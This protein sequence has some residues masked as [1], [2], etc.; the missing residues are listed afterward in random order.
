MVSI[1]STVSRRGVLLL[2]VLSVLTL[3]LMLGA[4]YV[5]VASRARKASRAFADNVVASTAGGMAQERLLDQAFM[6]VARGTLAKK[7]LSPASDIDFLGIGANGGDDLLGDKYGAMTAKGRVGTCANV[8]GSPA[9][10]RLTGTFTSGTIPTEI[11]QY[12]GRVITLSL[13]GLSASTRVISATGS[14]TSPSLFV[15]GGPTVAGEPLS[16]QRITAAIAASST[17]AT[18]L[19]LNGRE[20]DGSGANEPYD[21]YD[22]LNPLLTRTGTAVATTGTAA[23]N[24]GTTLTVDNDADGIADSAF[25]DVGLPPLLGANGQIVYP[26]AAILVL[27]LD[28]RLN[29]NAH[30]SATDAETIGRYPALNPSLTLSS[31][32]VPQY[33]LPRGLASGPADV[34][35]SRSL[36]F[37]STTSGTSE[38]AIVQAATY[39]LAGAVPSGYDTTAV[40][41]EVP[42]VGPVEGRFGDAVTSGS[43]AAI[44]GG[45]AGTG[46]PNHNDEVSHAADRWRVT[47]S[48]SHSATPF[49]TNPGRFGT[50]WDVKGQIR[51]WADEFGQPVFFKPTWAGDDAKDD[52]YEVNLT[53]LGSRN[54]YSTS[55][56]GTTPGDTLFTPAELEGL[57]RYYDPDSLKLPRRLVAISGS[58][59]A[60]NRLRLTTES[61]D[62][63]AVTGTTWHAAIQA[64]FNAMLNTADLT[65]PDRSFD[66]LS[67]ETLMGHKFDINRPFHDTD[68]EEPNDAKGT[69]RRQAFARHLYCLMIAVADK[70]NVF[71]GKNPTERA[72]LARQIAQYAVNVVD[73]RD[74]DSVMTRFAFDPQFGPSDTTWS[75]GPDDYVWGCE[76]PELLITETLAWHDRRTDD[77]AVNGKVV[78]KT[79][80][81]K[82]FDQVR[83]PRGAFFVELYSPWQARMAQPASGTA[84]MILAGSDSRADPIPGVLR[85]T[86]SFGND[87]GNGAGVTASTISLHKTSSGFPVWRLVSV[88]GRVLGGTAI[89]AT[90]KTLVDP[91][92]PGSTAIVDRV[93]Y[94]GD[95]TNSGTAMRNPSSPKDGR[96]GAIFWT[97]GTA[98]AEPSQSQYV[99]VGTDKWGFP[100]DRAQS[101]TAAVADALP[102]PKMINLRFDGA[103]TFASANIPATLSEPVNIQPTTPSSRDPYDV[104]A[105]EKGAVDDFEDDILSSPLD[106]PLDFVTTG[107]GVSTFFGT[108]GTSDLDAGRP[109]VM[110]NGTHDNFAAL[111]LQRLANPGAP[112][113]ATTNPYVT[114]DSMPVDLTVV[115]TGT[116]GSNFDEPGR[117]PVTPGTTD[118]SAAAL[119]WLQKQKTYRYE[120]VER[121]GKLPSP[122]PS[123]LPEPERDIWSRRVL[124]SGTQ[125]VSGS[126]AVS[127][128]SPYISGTNSSESRVSIDLTPLVGPTPS[129]AILKEVSPAAT[130]LTS[131]TDHTLRERSTQTER[132]SRPPRFEKDPTKPPLYPW[133]AWPNQPFGSVVD[134]TLVP[135]ASPFELPARH[136][137][138]A[139]GSPSP[140][141]FHLPRFFEST[142]PESPWDALAG[143]S[144]NATA[145]LFDFVHVPSPF[146]AVYTSVAATT[147][148]TTALA[149]VGLDLFPLNQIS[150]FREPGRVNVNTIPDGRVWRALFGAVN[151]KGV[152]TD[153]TNNPDDPFL[154][155]GEADARDRIPGWNVD[156]FARMQTGTGNNPSFAATSVTNLFRKIPERGAA[157]PRQTPSA[158]GFIDNFVAEPD[159]ADDHNNNG[160]RDF[161]VHR[162]TDR[163]AYFR[164][165]T[166]RQLSGVTTVR[167]HVF[168]VWITIRYVDSS[169]NEIEPKFRNRGF[170]IFDRSIPV[171]YE[172]GHDHNVRDAILLRRII[173]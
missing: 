150:N 132:E 170:Y 75:P 135:V 124:T 19:I 15:A 37:S 95:L 90:T 147:S 144:T 20:F 24:G 141:W 172:K 63:P 126:T 145:S 64:P 54:G 73:Y 84:A 103:A 2:V 47:L 60:A 151:V 154:N 105:T 78:D 77:G 173:Q 58:N 16:A 10:L 116:N 6:T 5:A 36:V 89:N 164:Y 98:T 128:T 112:W 158:G 43:V 153:Q 99:V 142:Q 35:L 96:P 70:N 21:G 149:T 56:A 3:F 110:F 1:T 85:Q 133:L 107:T 121:G 104:L 68:Y 134:L 139:P 42:R 109:L 81:D 45:S 166:M 62:T 9:L 65:A 14:P 120:S 32:M 87:V 12:P 160:T 57:L 127:G 92:A 23:L 30:G 80:A 41:R 143:R 88:R 17:A 148:S 27:D 59:A 167:S 106:E 118:P 33:Q 136:S 165:Q 155:S 74:G 44:S 113:N 137:T 157:G 122:L 125:L 152:A 168:G 102:Y 7:T 55:P 156:L 72:D 22:S 8:A 171:A 69:A 97:S 123:P 91:A 71:Q 31:T 25:L 138:A 83:R 108:D 146:A 66:F 169:G 46:R 4:A 94:L 111:H 163:H 51:V 34:S 48:G 86:G 52:P 93:F 11:S 115:N 50:P 119:V 39:A 18:T 159:A 79:N 161:N 49:W 140:K 28:G 61:W 101:G 129:D 162:D 67:P 130:V 82:H 29:V 40:T 114:V 76:R 53:R 117:T 100:Y 131:G 13:A 38:A 26:Q